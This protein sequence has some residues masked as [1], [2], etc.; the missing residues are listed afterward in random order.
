[1]STNGEFEFLVELLG[2]Q[3]FVNHEMGLAH[4]GRPNILGFVRV[5]SNGVADVVVI[6]DE[7]AACAWRT[8]AG[9]NGDVFAPEVVSWS[10]AHNPVWTLRAV[11]SL[12]PP[13]HPDEPVAVMSLPAG[14]TVAAG[15]RGN[16]RMRMR[17]W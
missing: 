3:R 17:Q 7:T 9:R 1:M 10:Y 15:A 13:G 16:Q 14:C 8:V 6:F 2:R 11:L 4:D 5:W 12:P